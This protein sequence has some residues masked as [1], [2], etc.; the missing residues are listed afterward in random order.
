VKIRRL[1]VR[2]FR[3]IGTLDWD[4]DSDLVALVGPGDVGKST[5]LDAIELALSPRWSMV[6]TENDFHGCDTSEPIEITCYV[7]DLPGALLSDRRFGL[8]L[9]GIDPAGVVHDEPLPGDVPVLA[10]RV[11]VDSSY[12]PRWAVVNNR[13]AAEGKPISSADRRLLGL[14]RLGL[15]VDRNLS[16]G[17]GSALAVLTEDSSGASAVIAAATRDMRAALRGSSF[18]SLDGAMSAAADAARK[19]GVGIDTS[20]LTAQ[21]NADAVDLRAPALGL[22]VRNVPLDRSGLGTRRLLALAIQR[23]TIAE[24]GIALIDEVESG[25]EPHRL[26]HLMRVLREAPDGQVIVTTHSS[27]VVTEISA[28][29]VAVVRRSGDRSATARISSVPPSL[30]A[31][32]RSNPDSVFARRIVVCEGATEIG[33]LR[34]VGGTAW[35]AGRKAPPSHVGAFYADGN[36][37]QTKARAL[38]FAELGYPC[39]VLADS[40]VEVDPRNELA[41]VGVPIVRWCDGTSIEER[42]F[43]DLPTTALQGLLELAASGL[44]LQSIEDQLASRAPGFVTGCSSIQELLNSNDEIALRLAAGQAAKAKDWFKRIDLGEQVGVLVGQHLAECAGTD[45][46]RG[47]RDVESWVYDDTPPTP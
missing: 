21:L 6:L 8:D 18:P 1:E 5:V 39:L 2:N 3:G 26:R 40:D 25:L 4:I 19:F 45:L 31:L 37:N 23:Q 44:G 29:N 16:W 14:T 10:V 32:V 28:P 30:Q 33:I 27:T 17:R 15:A 36:G 46:Q 38:G 11:S 42:L 9:R 34:G 41:A 43:F 47:L 35:S 22:H 20:E 13:L 7:S 12:E 24:G